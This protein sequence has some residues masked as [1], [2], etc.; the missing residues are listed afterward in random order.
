MLMK[1]NDVLKIISN[2]EKTYRANG[3]LYYNY[4]DEG[5]NISVDNYVFDSSNNTL[6]IAALI[7]L[8]Y[9][10]KLSTKMCSKLVKEAKE[11]IINFFNKYNTKDISFNTTS[12]VITNSSLNINILVQF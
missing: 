1:D 5:V 2:F 3:E 7:N 4:E 11:S 6:N 12:R 8:D 10:D 9:S